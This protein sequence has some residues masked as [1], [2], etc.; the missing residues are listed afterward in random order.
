MAKTAKWK[1]APE[2]H[3]FPAVDHYLALIMGINER[4][5][6]IRQL[7]RATLTHEQAKDLL[8]ASRLP[9]LPMD[10]PDVASDLKKVRKGVLLSPVLLMRGDA[11]AGIPMTVA[12]GYHR[13]CA[14][15]H[16]DE[17][18]EIPCLIADAPVRVAKPVGDTKSARSVRPAPARKRGD[19]GA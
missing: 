13:V 14:S 17:N 3:D 7:K 9:L 10:N 11:V 12:D 4:A 1:E 18:A 2:A 6:V 16:T 19:D 15:Y 5:A 8:R